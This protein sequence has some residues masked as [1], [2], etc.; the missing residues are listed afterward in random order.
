MKRPARRRASKTSALFVIAALLFV[1]GM[2]GSTFAYFDG[3]GANTG[4]FPGGYVF[5]PV[6]VTTLGAVTG[7][8]QTIKWAQPTTTGVN[9]YELRVTNMGTTTA[10]CPKTIVT[11]TLP[12]STLSTVQ[13]RTT[14]LIRPTT[15][16]ATT[17]SSTTP[18]TT[19]TAL[20]TVTQPVTYPETVATLAAPALTARA[21][22]PAG[23][24][25]YFVCYQAASAYAIDGWYSP[26]AN[27]N[28]SAVRAG[29]WPT[30][31]AK[32]GTAGKL[33]AG[34]SITITY[35]QNVS[36]SGSVTVCA[37]T[38]GVI[39]FGDQTGCTDS[40]AT[41]YSI[42]EITGL[43]ISTAATYSGS[44][45]TQPAANKVKVTLVG[46]P[47][48]FNITNTAGTWS[49]GG[50]IVTSVGPPSL[51]PC[52]QSSCNLTPSGSF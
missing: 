13:S 21:T 30:A 52:T 47:A 22:L 36:A 35:N 39:V 12:T 7:P 26:P 46:G 25:G 11:V 33:V 31:V 19:V 34:D 10:T 8:I 50:S 1:A 44:G 14:T 45:V 20:S 27:A 6:T 41:N 49:N 32:A 17:L 28:A 18:T 15:T 24:N 23:D 5:P 48:A 16:F 3:S 42:G 9:N 37:Y 29:L 2:A 40:S 43:S 38:A 4:T 51:S